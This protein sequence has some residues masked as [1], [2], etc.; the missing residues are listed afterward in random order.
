MGPAVTTV[1]PLPIAGAWAISPT[2]P[3]HND[4][5]GSFVEL[6]RCDQ[7]ADAIGHS[8]TL[9]Q[10]SLS[11][12]ACGVVRGIHYS[13]PGQTKYA[14][15]VRGS[16][17]DVV[18]DIRVGSPTFGA[19]DSICLDDVD[20]RAVY[21]SGDLG[22]GF[23]ALTDDATVLYLQSTLY[24]PAAERGLDPMSLGIDWPTNAPKLSARDLSSPT[25]IQAQ[26]Q[27]LLPTF[28]GDR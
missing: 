3:V 8:L 11:V 21:L 14:M 15:C 9:A 19:W 4:D 1:R 16:V 17:L 18:V 25:I 6:Y 26:Q 24:S 20:R 5:R 23:C 12:S 10:A 2:A 22:H 7:F 27:Q 28:R 13:V